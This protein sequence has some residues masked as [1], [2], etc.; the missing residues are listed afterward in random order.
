MI[1]PEPLPAVPYQ[2]DGRVIFET[3]RLI[4]RHLVAADAD[5]MFAVY[6]D[7]GAMRWVGD[8]KPLERERC[9]RWIDVT[10]RNYERYGYGM[11]ALLDRATHDVAGFIG[12]VHPNGQREA[13]IKYALRRD[14][15]GRGLASEA[16][17]GMLGYA[18]AV[19]GLD[20]VIATAAPEHVISHRVLS[21]AG[22]QRDGVRR[23]ADGSQTQMFAWRRAAS[24]QNDG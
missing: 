3:P 14:Y 23:N 19:L 18:A 22:L 13:E 11:T 9:V 6:G 21:K 4:A 17:T 15:W 16:A 12:L 7:A 20:H 24:G 10:H 2:P 1:V 5:A 8:G